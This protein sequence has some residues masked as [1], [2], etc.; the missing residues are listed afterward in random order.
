MLSSSKLIVILLLKLSFCSLIDAHVKQ[1][2]RSI[3]G[4]SLDTSNYNLYIDEKG[5]RFIEV[6]EDYMDNW[7]D[8][9]KMW[10]RVR[11]RI[12]LTFFGIKNNFDFSV[13][14]YFSCS[15]F[16]FLQYSIIFRYSRLFNSHRSICELF[17]IIS[18]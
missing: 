9:Q 1:Q 4:E 18:R 8:D 14:N 2:Q 15:L 11:Q 5:M 13:D 10:R 12:E 17:E 6:P 16:D 7:L 3:G